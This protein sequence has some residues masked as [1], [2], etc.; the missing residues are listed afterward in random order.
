VTVVRADYT[1]T[2]FLHLTRG[3]IFPPSGYVG[4]DELQFRMPALGALQ[5]AIT[6]SAPSKSCSNRFSRS[7]DTS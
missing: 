3:L 5:V 7:D 4:G 2:L 1:P 6:L